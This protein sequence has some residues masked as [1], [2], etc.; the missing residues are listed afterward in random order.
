M[1]HDKAIDKDLAEAVDLPFEYEDMGG[2][3][4]E[5]DLPEG[6]RHDRATALRQILRD[7]L[8]AG[9]TSGA[10]VSSEAL[11]RL[12]DQPEAVDLLFDAALE[13][14]AIQT[15]RCT[16]SEAE[17]SG[18]LPPWRAAY[19]KA[20]IALETG[21]LVA[22]RAILV[23][24]ID[25]APENPA[26]RALLAEAMVAAGTAADARAVLG[27]IGRPPVNPRP[28]GTDAAPSDTPS[29]IAGCGTSEGG[30]G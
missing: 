7:Q 25:A 20:R 14:G 3:Q 11:A 21:D 2:G 5:A 4:A 17:A 24:A 16:V 30:H 15:A 26:L 10:A 29:A 27:H 12:P 6:P 18:R 28:D 22:A 13:I 8:T 1:T 9:D 19:F 23:M